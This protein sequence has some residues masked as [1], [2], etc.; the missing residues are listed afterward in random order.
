MLEAEKKFF[1]QHRTEW[2]KSH[3]GKFALIKGDSLAGFFDTTED[4]FMVGVDKWGNV[5]ILIKQVLPEDPIEHIPSLTCGLI[6]AMV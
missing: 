3:Q 5:P 1:E 2:L 6:H 4:A